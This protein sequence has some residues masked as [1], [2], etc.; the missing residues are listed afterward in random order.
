MGYAVS[1]LAVKNSNSE[2]LLQKLDLAPTG[3]VT[4]YGESLF[5]G[6]RLST[7]WFVLFINQ[8]DHNFVCPE[9]LASLS[10]VGEAIA[11]SI[12]EHVMWCIAGLWRDGAQVWCIEHDAQKNISHIN[13]SGDLPEGYPAIERKYAELQEQSG[14]EK[15]GVDYFFE[16][17][18]QT[19]KGIVGFKHD[20]TAPEDESFQVFEGRKSPDAA[21]AH[22]DQNSKPWWK[23]W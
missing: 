1:W 17:P 6:C 9:T 8:C 5:T 22:L 15:S 13:A 10:A 4:L 19:A 14:G 7:G 16:I 20:E 18:L 11:C 21:G 23:L 12:E 2:L 3:E